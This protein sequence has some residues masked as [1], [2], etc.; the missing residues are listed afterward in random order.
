MLL[1][2]ND[3]EEHK[4]NNLIKK[5]PSD[6]GYDIRAAHDM[7]IMPK[8]NKTMDTGLHLC[9]PPILAG[10]VQSRS[11]LAIE[12]DIECSNAG[13]IDSGYYGSIKVKI[14]NMGERH[15]N[16]R[17]GDR[18]AQMIFHIRPEGFMEVLRDFLYQIHMGW[19][20]YLSDFIIEEKPMEE[21]PETSRGNNG[22]GST[23]IR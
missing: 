15:F 2:H 22:I 14:Y 9:I 7:V 11:G 1:M 5:H 3:V 12:K 6:M 19:E 20:T 10:I 18:I 4:G 21:W 16:I 23:G 17:K 13:V 8:C